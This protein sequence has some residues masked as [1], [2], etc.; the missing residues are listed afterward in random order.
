MHFAS[1]VS[2]DSLVQMVDISMLQ[3]LLDQNVTSDNS[4]S[5]VPALSPAAAGTRNSAWA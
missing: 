2:F 5:S 1:K 4:T 3:Q